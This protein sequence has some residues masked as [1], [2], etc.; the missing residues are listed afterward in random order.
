VAAIAE[1]RSRFRADHVARWIA[2]LRSRVAERDRLGFYAAALRVT[3]AVIEGD[4]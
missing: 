4:A 2:D 1:L 3:E